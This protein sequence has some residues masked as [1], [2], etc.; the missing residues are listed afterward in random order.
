MPTSLHRYLRHH[1]QRLRPGTS[2]ALCASWLP[3][4]L[5]LCEAC[6]TELPWLG[7]HCQRCALPLPVAGL[8]CGG[9]L[10][11]PPAFD[12]VLTPWRYAFPVDSLINA[13]K[14]RDQGNLGR[15]AGALLARHLQHLFD[16]GQPRPELLLPV[17]LSPQRLRQRGFNQ[18]ALLADWLGKPLGLPVNARLL[19]RVQEQHSQQGL[20]ASERRRNLKQAFALVNEAELTGR[21]LALVD[22]VLTTGATADS[23]ARL[24]KR[25]GARRIDVYCLARTPPPG[26]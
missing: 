7:P 3:S 1:W 22:D 21:H 17:P 19:Q 10:A 25:A 5:A 9:C 18:A 15:L 4:G 13:F 23:L 2:C 11:D 26:D 24:L 6:E 14:H 12:Q 8:I 16:E 20:T